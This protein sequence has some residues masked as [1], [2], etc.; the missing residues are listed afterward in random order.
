M[1]TGV[2]TGRYAAF[3]SYSHKDASAARALHG[4][5]ER[6][7][8]PKRLVGSAGDHGPVPARL[9][10]IFR[11][12]DELP[13]AGD[14]SEKVRAALAASDALV[15]VCSPHSA[16]SIWVAREIAVF[17]ELHPGR[18]IL[19]AVI[20]GEPGECFPE[21][22][23]GVD[24]AGAQIEP[25][26]ADLRKAGDGRRLG[27]LKLVA[28]L[29]GLGLDALIQRDTARQIRRVTAVT[30]AA[31][32]ATLV[33]AVLTVIALN[34]RKEADRQRAEAEGLVEFMLT[35]LRTKLKGVGRLDVMD[36]VNERA[37]TY[38]RNQ[39]VLSSLPDESL[40]QF[41]RVFHARGETQVTRGEMRAA[42]ENFREAH[43]VTAAILARHPRDTSAIFAHAQSEYWI[44]RVHELRQEW[45]PAEQR[46]LRYAE[47]GK[48]LIEIAPDNPEYM[49]ERGWGD[50]NL[51]HI[52]LQGWKKPEH[53]ETLFR[54][55]IA[56]FAEA[57][58]TP[59]HHARALREEANAYADLSDTFYARQLWREALDARQSEYAIN[60]R[61]HRLDPN[62]ADAIY[63]L[64]IAERSVAKVS[65]RAGIVA[66]SERLLRLAYRRTQWLVQREADNADWL[67]LN[68]KI[69][70]DLTAPGGESDAAVRATLPK[71]IAAAASSLRRR[72][73][74]RVAELARCIERL[75]I[76]T[77]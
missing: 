28:G 51:G 17:R 71:R 29:T 7:R 69:E 26:A 2:E 36:A 11:D 61:L 76:Q 31:I 21:A 5:L 73:N 53:A 19:A 16:A 64:A 41:A 72:N 65:Y 25:L 1:V 6:Y 74:P 12:R 9:T 66:D 77:T 20:A 60:M 33:M 75:K 67:L 24:A 14:L 40:E 44:G 57:A 35:D 18:P 10:P 27:F 3:I 42:L 55:A 43:A 39:G 52:Y 70:C 48:K 4:R 22:L 47:A 23:G 8:I 49:M 45:E 15:V 38:Y 30:L 46:Y 59:R 34:A 58:K 32:V 50:L 56:W 13:A 63:M 68:T 54:G 62:N 37:F